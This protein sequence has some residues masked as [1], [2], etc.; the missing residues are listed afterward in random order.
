MPGAEWFPGV[1]LNYAERVFA[2]R[3]DGATAILHASELR[4]L[5][6]AEPGASCAAEVA[7]VAAGL[8]EP[9]RRPRRPRRRLPAEH[10][11]GGRSRFLASASIGAIWS[12]RLARLRRRQ[13]HRPLRPDRAEGAAGG[14]RLPL[15][16]QGLRPHRRRS[17]RCGR[18]C[19][20]LERTVVHPLPRRRLDPAA[21]RRDEL[22]GAARAG[23]GAELTL[24]AASPSTTRS[25]SSTRSGTTGLPKAIVQGQGGILLEHLKKLNLHVD[26]AARRPPLLVHDDRLDDVE[27][28]RR[29]AADRRRRSS[30]TTATPATPTSARSG[31]SPS[32]PGSRCFGT[33]AAFIAAC[34]KAGVEPGDGPRPE[35]A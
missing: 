28:P 14:R 13:R 9:R 7:A 15:R 26:A 34:M 4:E 2:G 35:R 11:R 18:R 23:S 30:S 19:R 33:S 27:L 21:R 20:A 5:D 24:R 3:E 17:R 25:G 8:R 32:R 12:A 22:G 31:T 29:R 10:R 1:R 16:R 6:V